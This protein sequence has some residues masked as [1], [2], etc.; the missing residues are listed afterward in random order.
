MDFL[1]EA[2]AK[3]GHMVADHFVEINEMLFGNSGNC[4]AI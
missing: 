3:S 2:C 4:A 1:S